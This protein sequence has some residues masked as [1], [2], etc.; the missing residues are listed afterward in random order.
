M[1]G[2]QHQERVLA[3]GL[4]KTRHTALVLG[5]ML[6]RMRYWAKKADSIFQIQY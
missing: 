4:A 3:E 6:E 1:T 5:I 2:L